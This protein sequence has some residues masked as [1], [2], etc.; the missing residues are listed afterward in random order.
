[1][2]E[3]PVYLDNHATT[4][5]DPR[6]LQEMLPYFCEEY[7]NPA[8]ISHSYGTRAA[9][10]VEQARQQ[11]ADCVGAS[12]REVI[13]TSGATEASN[14]AL[15]GVLQAAGA[16]A[17]LVTDAAEH[18]AVLDPARKLKRQGFHLTVLPVDATGR[19][20]P[21]QVATAITSET[22]L[23]SVI[24][25]SNE[26]GTLN[27]LA[28]IGAICR[29][30]GVLLHT[31]AVQAVG[32]VPIDFRSLP[33]DLLSLS[34]H[35]FY[36]PKG[37]GALIVRRDRGRIRL[38]S[39]IDGGGHEQQLRSGTLAVPLIVGFGAACQ[40]VQAEREADAARLGSLRDDL[41]RRLQQELDGLWLNGHPEY[42]LPGNLNVSFEGVDGDALL[43]GLKRIA[44][45]SG[46]ACTSHNPEPSHVLRAMGRSDT[47]TRASLRFGIGRFNTPAEIELAAAE[48]VETVRRLRG[49]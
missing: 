6:V 46:S 9:E 19:L 24:L 18:R 8:S 15:R 33:V 37:T 4:R 2:A 26:V 49:K 10:A 29:E 39:Q 20:D 48:V 45:S 7:G 23:V 17:G 27:D 11:V 36:G 5:V 22:T 13:F 30:R 35:K 16:G 28:A 43:A 12:P 47:L 44:V 31:D 25:A 1:M 21:A 42:R 40:L 41:W 14:L 3:Q 32:T 38:V 34:A